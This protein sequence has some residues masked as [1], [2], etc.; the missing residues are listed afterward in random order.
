MGFYRAQRNGQHEGGFFVTQ[1]QLHAMQQHGLLGVGQAAQRVLEVQLQVDRMGRRG[2]WLDLVGILG[3]LRSP[4]LRLQETGPGDAVQP[5]AECRIASELVELAPRQQEDFLSEVVGRC[6]VAVQQA[7]Q[8]ST[9]HALVPAHELLECT[10][11]VAQQNARDQGL[12]D[13]RFGGAVSH[14]CARA[15]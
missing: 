1:A 11:V 8:L 10:P 14:A 5:G 2:R 9:H 12:V 6:L 13:A 4:A 15:G 3:T 7:A